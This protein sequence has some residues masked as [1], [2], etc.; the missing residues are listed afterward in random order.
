MLRLPTNRSL[1][2]DPAVQDII[3]AGFIAGVQI[4]CG[5]GPTFGVDNLTLARLL[6]APL[7]LPRGGELRAIPR[8]NAVGP[9]PAGFIWYEIVMMGVKDI[10]AWAEDARAA[11][12]A[13]ARAAQDLAGALRAQ[14][15]RACVPGPAQD[16]IEVYVGGGSIRF[17]LPDKPLA[18]PAVPPGALRWDEARLLLQE[19]GF[20][21]AD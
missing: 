6:S 11:L 17:A 14:G 21:L 20:S 19:A 9:W 1:I 13:R 16:Y 3:M 7:A 10:F 8:R 5:Y 12:D 18:I 2:E 15:W 4:S